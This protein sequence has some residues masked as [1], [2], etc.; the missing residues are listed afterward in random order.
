MPC[1]EIKYQIAIINP[2]IIVEGG[3][4]PLALYRSELW[5]EIERIMNC[6]WS[7]SLEME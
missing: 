7:D 6:D 2:G 5:G 1:G 4:F 3:N